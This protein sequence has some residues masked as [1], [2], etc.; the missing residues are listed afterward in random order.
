M[1]EVLF[2]VTERLLSILGDEGRK[3]P[4]QL[5]E[6]S[7]TGGTQLTCPEIPPK[8]SCKARKPPKWLD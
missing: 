2:G 8:D 3:L 5:A 6:R 7:M 4:A 1:R